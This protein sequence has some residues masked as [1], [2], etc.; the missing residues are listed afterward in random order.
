VTSKRDNIR[1]THGGKFAKGFSANPRGNPRGSRHK[2]TLAAEAL[3]DGDAEALTRK[4]VE[5]ALAGDATAMRLCLDRLIPPRRE[6]PVSFAL[7]EIK[8]ATD[9][10]G[11]TTALAGAVAVG[12][13]V[14]GEAAALSSLLANVAKAIELGEIEERLAR[15]EAS[16]DKRK[17]PWL[18]TILPLAP[19]RSGHR[20]SEPMVY[21]SRARRGCRRPSAAPSG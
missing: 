5:M 10:I 13:L 4:C 7:P 20:S 19:A 21:R 11:A 9:I 18:E 2:A 1:R 17:L 3:L 15:L 8:K 16:V 14:P 6:R 12:E